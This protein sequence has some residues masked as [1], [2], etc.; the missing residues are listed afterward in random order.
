MFIDYLWKGVIVGL[1]AS[2]PLGPVGVL[3]IQ[4]T[5]NKGRLSGLI[6]GLGAA[7]AD[8]FYAVIAGFGVAVI[9]DYLEK[10]QIYFR[11]V[12][13]AILI[14]MGLRLLFTNPGLQLRRQ[15]RKKRKGLLGDFIS[16][17][18]LT[19]SNPVTLFAFITFFAG[20]NFFDSSAN[21][22]YVFVLLFGV[23]LGAFTWW[24]SLTSVVSIFRNKFRLRRMLIINRVAG[25]LVVLFGIF[26]FASV[27]FMNEKKKN[28]TD[29]IVINQVRMKELPKYMEEELIKTFYF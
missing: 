29:N 18:A 15:L 26:V 4:R 19:I 24:F 2:I 25:I 16:I 20:L 9:I 21:I 23:L 12:G 13:A 28:L 17:F 10:Y 14:I 7:C 5:L 6:S 11:I 27:F 3:C 22:W 1:A 8:G